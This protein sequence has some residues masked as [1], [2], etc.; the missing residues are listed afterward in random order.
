[1]SN[2]LNS[3]HVFCKLRGKRHIITYLR[4]IFIS[5][6]WT[7]SWFWTLLYL[8]GTSGLKYLQFKTKYNRTWKLERRLEGVGSKFRRQSYMWFIVLASLMKLLFWS[9]WIYVGIWV[10]LKTYVPGRTHTWVT[11]SEHQY[12]CACSP[13]HVWPPPSLTPPRRLSPAQRGC[14]RSW[15][16]WTIT[17]LHSCR[18]S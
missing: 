2:W 8:W 4:Y 10:T 11:C 17:S 18:S 5:L 16:R 15:P 6:T 9:D 14:R 3:L 12:L 7:I 13:T 1:M